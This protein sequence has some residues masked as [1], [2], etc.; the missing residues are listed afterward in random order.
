MCFTHKKIKEKRKIKSL[1]IHPEPRNPEFTIPD[2]PTPEFTMDESIRCQGCFQKFSLDQIKINCAGCDKFFHCKVAG[3]CYGENCKEETRAGRLH[4][5]SWCT[6]CVPKIPEN[7]EKVNREE[8][9][10]CNECHP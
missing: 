10:I 2:P 8:P 7:K 1:K 9:C 4:R 5:L 3:T 6:N